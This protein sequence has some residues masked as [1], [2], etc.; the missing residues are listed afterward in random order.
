MQESH[1]RFRQAGG[2]GKPVNIVADDAGIALLPERLHV[3]K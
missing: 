3:R 2:G 1:Q